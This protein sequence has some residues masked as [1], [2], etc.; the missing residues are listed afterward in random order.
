MKQI[1]PITTALLTV[2][3]LCAQTAAERQKAVHYLEQTR[4]GVVAATKGL[5]DAQMKFKAGPDRSGQ[6][7]CATG[8][9]GRHPKQTRLPSVGAVTE[10]RHRAGIR[11]C[12]EDLALARR[13][14][15]RFQSRQHLHFSSEDIDAGIQDCEFFGRA[16]VRRSPRLG[17]PRDRDRTGSK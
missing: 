17:D 3:A 10:R 16:R 15:L 8:M 2:S 13:D 6:T 5:S 9:T 14:E 12:Q 7:R 4:D 11:I 1:V